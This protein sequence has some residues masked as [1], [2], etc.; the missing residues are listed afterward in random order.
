MAWF[1]ALPSKI[2]F[3]ASPAAFQ[4]LENIFLNKIFQ[5]AGSGGLG[6][7]GQGTIFS[8]GQI[9]FKIALAR[10]QQ[11]VDHF[12][13]AWIQFCSGKFLPEARLD[14]DTIDEFL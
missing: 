1:E 11:G 14:Q 10:I 2:V 5:V 13:L 6:C 12:F 3:A 8:R 9:P 7:F 4:A